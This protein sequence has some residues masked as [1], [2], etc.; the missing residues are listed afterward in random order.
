MIA[1]LL[2][3]LALA[4]QQTAHT[5]DFGVSSTPIKLWL[6]TPVG[7]A[8]ETEFKRSLP[9]IGALSIEAYK[10][11]PSHYFASGLAAAKGEIEFATWLTAGENGGFECPTCGAD[12]EWWLL[13]AEMGIYRNKDVF[14]GGADWL[15]DY[16]KR[17]FDHA[18]SMAKPRNEPSQISA[19]RE[20]LGSL[21]PI[22]HGLFT[23]FKSRVRCAQ[24]GWFGQHP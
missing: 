2:G 23:N 15:D 12:H 7:Q 9:Q 24:C 20:L 6:E 17:V 1:N 8:A 19:L 13:K 3:G 16:D 14:G 5:D 11:D 22:T 21:D 10:A 18:S 4:G